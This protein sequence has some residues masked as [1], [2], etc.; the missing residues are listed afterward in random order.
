MKKVMQKGGAKLL[1]S[2]ALK[3]LLGGT[4]VGAVVAG[5]LLLSDLYTIYDIL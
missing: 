3:T 2:V 5:G 1:G 4:G